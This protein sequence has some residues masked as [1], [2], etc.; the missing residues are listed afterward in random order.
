MNFATF[1][2]LFCS[3]IDSQIDSCVDSEA[4]AESELLSD[5]Q[6]RA[7]V[8]HLSDETFI[9]NIQEIRTLKCIFNEDWHWDAFAASAKPHNYKKKGHLK[10]TNR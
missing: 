8:Q 5:I 10:G 6:R 7:A 2:H 9:L 3:I 1:S 4:S